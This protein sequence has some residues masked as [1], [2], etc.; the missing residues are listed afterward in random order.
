MNQLQPT[1]CESLSSTKLQK[2]E[3]QPLVNVACMCI[4]ILDL[5]REL[6]DKV[7]SITS[8]KQPPW[9]QDH[10]VYLHCPI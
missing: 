1:Q 4:W 9:A 6:A 8:V 3:S 2:L 5:D 7:G 10:Q